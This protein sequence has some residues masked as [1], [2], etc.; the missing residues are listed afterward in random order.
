MV[1]HP[2]ALE[3]KLTPRGCQR[4]RQARAGPVGRDVVGGAVGLVALEPVAGDDGVDQAPVARPQGLGVE[5]G[6]PECGHTD[7]GEEDVGRIHQFECEGAALV[8]TEVDDDAPLGPV[9]ELEHGV[10]REVAPEHAL[11][12]PRRVPE[13]RLDLDDVRAPVRQ[14]PTGGGAGD[15]HA[16]LDH[17]DA[18]HRPRGLLGAHPPFPG[19]LMAQA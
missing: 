4:R 12:R 6:P 18:R 11:E 7:V 17:A 15:P 16:E 8:G 14:D 9:V 5:A 3:R 19:G 13:G 10:G 1:A 2:S